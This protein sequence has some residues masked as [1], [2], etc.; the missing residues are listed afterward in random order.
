MFEGDE[1]LEDDDDLWGEVDAAVQNAPVS[2][3]RG[4]E[5]IV[6]KAPQEL[7]ESYT[8]VKALPT[9]CLDDY[10]MAN[11]VWLWDQRIPKDA[12]SVIEGHPGIG[13]SSVIMDL[14]ARMTTGRAWP[15]EP[16]HEK[17]DVLRVLWLTLEDAPSFTLLPRLV[18]AGGDPKQVIVGTQLPILG[19]VKIG[20][21][22]IELNRRR[23]GR[24]VLESKCDVVV[25]DP[26][27][28]TLEDGNSETI[29]RQ[30]FSGLYHLGEAYG[31][32]TL[33]I[34]HLAKA[35]GDRSPLMAGIGSIGV[36]AAAR[37]VMQLIG[38]EKQMEDGELHS[39]YLCHV[40]SNLSPYQPTLSFGIQG[41][42][43][44]GTE[45]EPIYSTVVNWGGETAIT[46]RALNQKNS[47][48]GTARGKKDMVFEKLEEWFQVKMRATP[49]EV[50]SRINQLAGVNAQELR[51]LG[52]YWKPFRER[53][54][55]REEGT[56]RAKVFVYSQLDSEN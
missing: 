44:P 20:Q 40:K 12:V 3:E 35:S 50:V 17:H 38:D 56:G 9:R 53:C 15:G 4:Q 42:T 2:P 55:I 7:P 52:A 37:S 18:A 34:R 39:R 43:V 24:T 21:D 54:E 13:K 29:A 47:S 27:S 10:T 26:G 5:T 33:W 14:V 8:K 31:I 48:G 1:I 11:P 28:A 22:T 36:A 46:A 45:E 16:G 19:G 41:K 23:F 6:D 51:K 25:M 30:V 49:A 32:T